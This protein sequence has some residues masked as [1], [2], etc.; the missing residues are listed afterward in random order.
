MMNLEDELFIKLNNQ[1]VLKEDGDIS[2]DE[3]SLLEDIDDIF[4]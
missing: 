1:I 3:N 4:D 2:I